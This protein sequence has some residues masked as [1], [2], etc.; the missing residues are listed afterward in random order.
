MTPIL[1][2][3]SEMFEVEGGP[4][5]T[6]TF[7]RFNAPSGAEGLYINRDGSMFFSTN[8]NQSTPGTAILLSITNNGS[9][10]APSLVN[11]V[12][13]RWFELT[14]SAAK[15]SGTPQFFYDGAVSPYVVKAVGITGGQNVGSGGTPTGGQYALPVPAVNFNS[16]VTVANVQASADF[17][18]VTAIA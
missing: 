17:Y 16:T 3:F 10:V 6:G 12:N 2:G 1:T 18:S 13:R 5:L 8:I 14:Y 7:V 9:G 4:G 11:F 15:G